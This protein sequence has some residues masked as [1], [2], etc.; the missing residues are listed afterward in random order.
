MAYNGISKKNAYAVS[1]YDSKMTPVCS[2]DAE[3]TI[4]AVFPYLFKIVFAGL[5]EYICSI[6]AR[7]D[8]PAEETVEVHGYDVTSPDIQKLIFG[9]TGDVA[10]KPSED[11]DV[12]NCDNSY[13]CIEGDIALKSSE[14][15]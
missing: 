3:K 10:H 15:D 5:L 13:Y 9:R 12:I 11:I 6:E 7:I 8:E 4:E 2:L 14:Y 1:D